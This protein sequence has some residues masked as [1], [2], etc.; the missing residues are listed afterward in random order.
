MTT[1]LE[2]FTHGLDQLL[3]GHPGSAADQALQAANALLAV[4][5]DAESHPPKDLRSRWISRTQQTSMKKKTFLQI[6]RTRPVLATILAVIL[7]T[8]IVFCVAMGVAYTRRRKSNADNEQK[9]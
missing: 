6:F 2:N 5:L 4:D 8:L 7:G 9:V 1:N 3:A